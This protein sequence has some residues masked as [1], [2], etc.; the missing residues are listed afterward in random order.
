MRQDL[1]AF[2]HFLFLLTVAIALFD[3]LSG[4]A[5]ATPHPIFQADPNWPKTLPNGCV[6]GPSGGV[7]VDSHDNVWIY[8]RPTTVK[9]TLNN[10]PDAENGIPAPS[11]VELSADGR[12][13]QGWGTIGD[14]PGRSSKV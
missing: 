4:I 2:R 14:K 1:T 7:T 13:I 11:V 3:L 12:F 6:F 10:P 8:S 9:E 5:L